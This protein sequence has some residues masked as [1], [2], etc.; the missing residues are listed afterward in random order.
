M[1][2]NKCW[3]MLSMLNYYSDEYLIK[4]GGDE[5]DILD[6]CQVHYYPQHV[7]EVLSPFHH[8]LKREFFDVPRIKKTGI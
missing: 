1:K 3:M 8:S 6:F 2:S 4:F 5:K 7:D